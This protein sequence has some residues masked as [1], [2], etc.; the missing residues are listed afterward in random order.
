MLRAGVI[1]GVLY[2]YYI[3]LVIAIYL[4]LVSFTK[5]LCESELSK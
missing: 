2:K 1:L 5:K 3:A 4:N